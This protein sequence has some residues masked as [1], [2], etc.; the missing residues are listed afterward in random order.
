[1]FSSRNLT[2]QT[3]FNL[4]SSP[5]FCLRLHVHV[6]QSYSKSKEQVVS[7]CVFLN[8]LWTSNFWQFNTY[9]KA[10]NS[11]RLLLV[12]F[13]KCMQIVKKCYP[14]CELKLKNLMKII[15]RICRFRSTQWALVLI[16]VFDFLVRLLA[17]SSLLIL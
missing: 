14:N 9:S 5:L 7:L 4:K 3:T 1:M 10:L 17:F 8:F 11:S 16:I 2:N 13:V 15:Y 12:K 6:W